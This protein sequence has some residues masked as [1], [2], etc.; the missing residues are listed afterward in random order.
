MIARLRSPGKG[1]SAWVDPR[2]VVGVCL[3]GASV[4]G[5]TTIVLAADKTV[6]IYAAS[7]ALSPGDQVTVEDLMVH[8]VRLGSI[9]TRYLSPGDL[10]LEGVVVTKPIAS[11]E[12][13]PTSAVG[14]L[15]GLRVAPVVLP[16]RAQLARTVAAGSPVDVWAAQKLPA[17]GFGAPVVLADSATV[18]R[19]IEAG[20]IAASSS[21]GG[22]EVLVPRSRLARVLQAVANNEAISLV[23]ASI[24][25]R[26]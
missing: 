18:V 23:P 2:L 14:S 17:G 21:T 7:S 20:G 4:L 3:V 9:G 10:P 5:V 6:E 8:H 26:D 25:V 11:G 16:V 12:L 13:V 22:I 19:I 24:P 1:R 15:A